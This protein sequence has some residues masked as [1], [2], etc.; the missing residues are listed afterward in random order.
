MIGEIG[1]PASSEVV[2]VQGGLVS[3]GGASHGRLSRGWTEYAVCAVAGGNGRSVSGRVDDSLAG[4]E[5]SPGG[6]PRSDGGAGA[7]DPCGVFA[8]GRSGRCRTDGPRDQA[9][10]VCRSL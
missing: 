4:L 1:Y 9:A 10:A 5:G 3:Q 6:R 8:G 2:Q 7:G